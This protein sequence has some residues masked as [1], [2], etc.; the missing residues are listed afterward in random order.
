M[1]Q[2]NRS[3]Q[4]PHRCIDYHHVDVFADRPFTGN[5]LCVFTDV[6][7]DAL[8]SAALLAIT[9]EM[10]QFE[11]IFLSPTDDDKVVARVFTEEEE[12]AFAGHPILGAAAV[13]HA[14]HSA[15]QDELRWRFSIAGRTI[16]VSTRR[17]AGI[18]HAEMNQGRAELVTTLTRPDLEKLVA[19]LDLAAGDLH[20]TLQAQVITTGLPYLI[21]PVS[22]S[23]LARA[24]ILGSGFEAGLAAHG[25]K[26]VYVF[27]PERRE[28]RTWDNHG[29]TEDVATGS[30]AGPAGA[31]LMLQGLAEA[32][33]AFTLEQ[34]RF[35]GRPSKIH[36]RIDRSTREIYVGGP[37]ARV[38]S[39]TLGAPV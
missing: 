32:G 27:D 17:T 23:G 14:R 25:A 35:I 15:T 13:L 18:M 33:S 8:P 9:Q 19:D 31:L 11:S 6:D 5:G 21:I 29:R 30:A 26:F 39:G 4:S 16:A 10:R 7:I 37:V 24:R 28:G 20:P 1:S 34:G 38:A 22:H 12:L 2:P 36:V 3:S